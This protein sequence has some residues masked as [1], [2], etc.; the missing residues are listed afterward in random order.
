MISEIKPNATGTL[1]NQTRMRAEMDVSPQP[2][3]STIKDSG[4]RALY[5]KFASHAHD[6][7]KERTDLHPSF[8]GVLQ[9][10]ADTLDLPEGSYHI[11]LRTKDGTVF[12]YAQF[13]SVKNRPKPVLATILGGTM[14]PGGRD[15]SEMLSKAADFRETDTFPATTE[16]EPAQDRPPE[17]SLIR[18]AFNA[19]LGS[20]GDAM[21]T[22]TQGS[23]GGANSFG[24]K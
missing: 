2:V 10:A 4:V 23:T 3:E 6:R 14:K 11:P 5:A 24:G 13:K 7:M 21:E 9:R 16:W 1:L 20:T 12:G 17:Q 22:G 18:R 8:V 15:L 19:L